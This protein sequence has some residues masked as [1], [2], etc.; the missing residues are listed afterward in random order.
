MGT[1]ATR[2]AQRV[3]VDVEVSEETLTV[4]LD[5]GRAL[6]VP[7]LWYPRLAEGT[8]PE[9]TRWAL[10]GSGRGIRW[11]DLDEDISVEALLAGRPS[12]ESRSSLEKWRSTR[13]RSV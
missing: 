9:R 4:H 11:Q 7:L 8:P 12:N 10:T 13:R 2:S 6:A 5:D 3:A 1:S